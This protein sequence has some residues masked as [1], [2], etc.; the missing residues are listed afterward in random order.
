MH[1]A[2]FMAWPATSTSVSCVSILRIPSTTIGWSSTI[3]V[4]IILSVLLC[5][6]R[7][8]DLEWT[9][10]QVYPLNIQHASRYFST[11]PLTIFQFY[12]YPFLCHCPLLLRLVRHCVVPTV[13]IRV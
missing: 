9:E 6:L 3:K 2:A 8:P 12:F 4:R 11:P 5:G 10:H 1:E 13:L 7:F